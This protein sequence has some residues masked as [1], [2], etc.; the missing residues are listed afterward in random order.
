[1][2]EPGWSELVETA[3]NVTRPLLS[4]VTFYG[5]PYPSRN[6]PAV[7]R[8]SDGFDYVVKARTRV[9]IRFTVN[10][11]VA[12][13]LGLSMVA[14]VLDP[15]IVYVHPDLVT[16]VPILHDFRPGHCYGTL[17]DPDLSD[18]FGV[19]EANWSY[20]RPRFAKIAV[21]WGLLNVEGDHQLQYKK[22]SPY[23]VFAIDHEESIAA[24]GHWTEALL[25][26]QPTPVCHTW[27][28]SQ[29]NV[30]SAELIAVKPFLTSITREG[31]A[32]AAAFPPDS[33]HISTEERV[34]LASFLW[35]RIQVLLSNL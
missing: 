33:W 19:K 30:T 10:D 9:P 27:I 26:G 2:T 4:A 29:A 8:C 18:R 14:P 24:G 13:K 31:V 6:Q 21:L 17:Q 1:M 28:T 11:A 35:D 32:K 12:A 22:Q 16:G 25:P 20:N 7:F 15:K 5:C 23:E 34:A 3:L